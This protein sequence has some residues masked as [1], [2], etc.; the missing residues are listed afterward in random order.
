M[1]FQFDFDLGSPARKGGREGDAVRKKCPFTD[2]E[3]LIVR[4]E[5][6]N[7]VSVSNANDNS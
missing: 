4:S 7:N 3:E 6:S 5:G 2:S 1:F